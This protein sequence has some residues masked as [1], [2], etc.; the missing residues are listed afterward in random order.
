MANEELEVKDKLP[1]D[2]T[3]EME[4]VRPRRRLRDFIPHVVTLL[5]AIIIWVVAM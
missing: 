1:I 2:E 4:A 3:G 5:L